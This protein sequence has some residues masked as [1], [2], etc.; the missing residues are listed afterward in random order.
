M[1]KEVVI[2]R[3]GTPMVMLKVARVPGPVTDKELEWLDRHRV[4]GPTPDEDA[5]TTLSGM[6]DEDWR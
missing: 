5:G 3:H 4:D 1:A 6:R 2:T